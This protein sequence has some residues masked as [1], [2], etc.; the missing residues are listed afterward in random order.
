VG[1]VI[2]NGFGFPVE[3]V[4]GLDVKEA[5]NSGSKRRRLGCTWQIVFWSLT[6]SHFVINPFIQEIISFVLN[7]TRGLITIKTLYYDAIYNT[8]LGFWIIQF[9]P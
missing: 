3:S 8:I 7:F 1:D 4:S 6:F 2:E 5:M 9:D